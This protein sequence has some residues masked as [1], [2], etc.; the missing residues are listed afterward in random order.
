MEHNIIVYNYFQILK[1]Y[2]NKY[3]VYYPFL[4]SKKNENVNN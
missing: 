2:K 3:C 4:K 1:F